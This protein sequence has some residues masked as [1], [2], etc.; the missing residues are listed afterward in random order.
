MTGFNRLKS[1]ILV[2]TALAIPVLTNGCSSKDNPL[3]PNSSPLCCSEF[4]VGGTITAD[5]GGSASSQVAVQAVADIA[6]IATAAIDDLTTACRGIAIDLDTPQADQDAAEGTADKNGKMKAWC[7]AAVKA[8][9]TAKAG[10]SISINA[11]PPACEASVSAKLDCQ[12]KCS[13]SAK[14]DFKANPPTCTGG[15]LTVSCKGA[16]T[17]KAGASLSCTGSCS[18]NCTGSCKAEGGVECTGKCEGE[19]SASGAG[20]TGTGIQADGTCKGTCKGTCSATAP[21]VKCE[22][23]C[24]GS[25]DATCQGSATASVKCDGD[26]VGDIEPISCSGGKLEGGCTVDAKCDANCNGSVQAKATCTPP[27][28]EVTITG[29]ADANIVAKVVGTLKANFGV[30]LALQSRF[31][32]VASATASLKDNVGAV[33]DIKLACI[34]PLVAAAGQAIVDIKDAGDQTVALAGTITVGQ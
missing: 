27:S 30:I 22:G 32:L 29:Q 15:K 18:G 9:G 3:D 24:S 13:G 33:A 28:F 11:K 21:S 12:A 10:G 26:C 14:C 6:G 4:K 16:C 1:G 34:P 17:A 19:C 25:C 20:G 5:I 23:S 31:S 2:A 7:N 8:I